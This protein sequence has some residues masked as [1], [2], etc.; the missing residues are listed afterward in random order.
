[1]GNPIIR[2]DQSAAPAGPMVPHP[3]AGVL[4]YMGAD[5]ISA[6]LST[7]PPAGKDEPTPR[8]E[9]TLLVPGR[10]RVRFIM[11]LSSYRHKRSTFWHWVATR[12][13]V[14]APGSD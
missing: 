4:A 5:A 12:A 8:R 11:E 7:C 2:M 1:M 3:E 10:G 14:V 6:A 9:I 13:D